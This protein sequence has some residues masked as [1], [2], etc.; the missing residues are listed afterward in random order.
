MS[1]LSVLTGD[2]KDFIDIQ[3]FGDHVDL[4]VA[5][6]EKATVVL[7]EKMNSLGLPIDEVRVDE[8]TLENVFVTR[9]RGLGQEVHGKPFP[10]RHDHGDL[11]GRVAM[12]ATN[13]TKT[14][15]AIHG[16]EE[17]QLENSVWGSIRASWREWRRQNDDDQN[18]LR[19]AGCV[20]WKDGASR[21]NFKFAFATYTAGNWIYVAEIFFV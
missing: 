8:P 11:R 20:E 3:R 6:A 1:E 5:D 15:G 17:R 18:A 12:G 19:T 4:L 10:V 21:R 13:L 14:F 9:L 2:D 16:G 7:K